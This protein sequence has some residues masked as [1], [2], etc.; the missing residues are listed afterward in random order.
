MHLYCDILRLGLSSYKHE[1]TYILC[2]FGEDLG[3]RDGIIVHV[4]LSSVLATVTVRRHG[5]HKAFLKRTL[6]IALG[7]LLGLYS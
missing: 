4:S 6:F 3:F 7:M 1:Y 5:K 2:L